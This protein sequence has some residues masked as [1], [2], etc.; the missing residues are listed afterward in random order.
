MAKHA[1][2][3]N[4]ATLYLLGEKCRGWGR[5]EE[6][7]R[8]EVGGGKAEGRGGGWVEEKRGAGRGEEGGEQEGGGV[9]EGEG[10]GGVG[11]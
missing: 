6:R 7:N 2:G 4:G 11:S 1:G 5:G 10:I 9:E 3:G 8:G